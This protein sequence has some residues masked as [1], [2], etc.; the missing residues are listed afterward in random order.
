MITY[1]N[2]APP[3]CNSCENL[4][5]EGVTVCVGFDDLL[6]FTLG[7]NHAQFDTFIVVTS[8]E[9]RKTQ[10]VAAKH[11][12]TCVPTD[13]FGKNGRRFNKG[14]AINAG[15]NYFQYRGWRMHL[16]SDI[17]LPDNFRRL[18]FNHHHLETDC[19]YGADRVDVIGSGSIQSLR[20]LF[21]KSPPHRLRFLVDPTH[22]RELV[23]P[24]GGRMVN[25]LE[26]YLPLGYFQLWH[27]S[28]QRQYPWSLGSAA[29][30]DTMFSA[31][32]PLRQR[33]LLP[34][35]FVYHCCPSVPQWGENWDGQRKQVRLKA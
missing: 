20:K 13:L 21:Q 3:T 23:T 31:L 12:A 32:W 15:F 27:A 6:D 1:A 17:A 29:H 18:L 16:D 2:A 5:L 4:R 26:G 14:A 19:L 35:V 25:H 10:Q 22:D 28:R 30:D 9:D 8:H 34:G 7:M 24:I 33:R 11:G